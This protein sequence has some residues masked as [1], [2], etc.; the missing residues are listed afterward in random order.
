MGVN[1]TMDYHALAEK[2]VGLKTYTH[3]L[4]VA[5]KLSA[6]EG[7][8]FLALNYLTMYPEAIHPKE[9]SQK[10][11]ISSARVAALLNHMEREGLVVRSADP[12]DGRKILVS[13]TD[14]GQQLIKDKTSEM[15]DMMAQTLEEL[16][17]EEAEAYYRI[18]LKLVQILMRRT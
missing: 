10:M 15:V 4:P 17:S 12:D 18:Q 7:G 14:A 16:G 5:R 9:L 13:L 11:A 3:L 6:L 8:T 2:L 1:F